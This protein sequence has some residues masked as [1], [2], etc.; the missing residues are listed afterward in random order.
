MLENIRQIARDLRPVLLE[1]YGLA[2]AIEAMMLRVAESA[3]I[4]FDWALD[5]VDRLLTKEQE[6]NLYRI[7]QECVS[8]VIKHADAREARVSLRRD[9]LG[10]ELIIEDDGKGM[11]AGDCVEGSGFGLFNMSHRAALLGGEMT[12]R[13]APGAGTTISIVVPIPAVGCE[14]VEIAEDVTHA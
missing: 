13:S 12:V 6:T 11:A 7:A 4:R 2:S 10:V 14:T 1:R 5:P 3:P 9:D 8:N